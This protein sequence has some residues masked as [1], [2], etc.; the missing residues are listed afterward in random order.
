MS[1]VSQSSSLKNSNNLS[2]LRRFPETY[3]H[4]HLRNQ[5]AQASSLVKKLFQRNFQQNKN[6]QMEMYDPW[7]GEPH[8]WSSAA[9]ILRRVHMLGLVGELRVFRFTIP[10]RSLLCSS[11]KTGNF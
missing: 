2:G 6:L 10:R 5:Q 7:T 8:L 3:I 11:L 9:S 1:L 4:R